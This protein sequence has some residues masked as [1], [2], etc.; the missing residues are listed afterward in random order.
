M[1]RTEASPD[2][3]LFLGATE[4][5]TKVNGW[6]CHHVWLHKCAP[7]GSGANIEAI[8]GEANKL[9]NE[10]LQSFE[11]EDDRRAAG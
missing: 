1:I 4:L 9:L 7:R 5:I 6:R 11:I 2:M 10:L 8:L 3:S